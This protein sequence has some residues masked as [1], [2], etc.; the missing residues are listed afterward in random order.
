MKS[1][2]I[3]TFKDNRMIN[4]HLYKSKIK[5]LKSDE[6]DLREE[7][8]RYLTEEVSWAEEDFQRP[9]CDDP[10]SVSNQITIHV[11]LS[12][13]KANLE[14]TKRVL[15]TNECKK[16]CIVTLPRNAVCSNMNMEIE[17]NIRLTFW[18]YLVIRVFVGTYFNY[19][20]RLSLTIKISNYIVQQNIISF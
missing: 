20:L 12:D 2:C 13:H 5:S 9:I 8:Q 16:K 6:E 1:R 10:D 7:R 18:L 14:A 3:F 4:Y 17:Y 11:R 15:S 19:L